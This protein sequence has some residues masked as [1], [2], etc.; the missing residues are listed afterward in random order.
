MCH[1]LLKETETKC[2]STQTVC[3]EYYKW[4]TLLCSSMKSCQLTSHKH[5]KYIKNK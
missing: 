5:F 4:E 3:L 2:L 1:S